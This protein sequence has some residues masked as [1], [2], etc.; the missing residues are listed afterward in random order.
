MEAG[1]PTPA[2]NHEEFLK[3]LW[4]RF[5]DESMSHHSS[6]L[7]YRRMLAEYQGWDKPEPVKTNFVVKI[8]ECHECAKRE[9]QAGK[10]KTP[11]PNYSFGPSGAAIF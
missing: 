5:C 6:T 1:T 7:R 10:S 3:I 2:I 8:G 9:A 11:E 4:S